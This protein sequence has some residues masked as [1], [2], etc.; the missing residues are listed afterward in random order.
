[1]ARSVYLQVVEQR[2]EAAVADRGAPQTERVNVLRGERKRMYNV[3]GVLVGGA[4]QRDRMESAPNQRVVQLD[5]ILV[6][7]RA[8]LAALQRRQYARPVPRAPVQHVAPSRT[9]LGQ[10]AALVRREVLEKFAKK[11][12]VQEQLIDGADVRV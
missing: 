10:C 1:M 5:A 9:H 8:Q 7:H 4:E 3:E 2:L 11:T 12:F 6:G